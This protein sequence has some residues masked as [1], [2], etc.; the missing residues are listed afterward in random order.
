M[1]EDVPPILWLW[2]VPT[3]DVT[4]TGTAV[5]TPNNI[6]GNAAVASTTDDNGGVGEFSN[7]ANIA[8]VT[9]NTTAVIP[10]NMHI[11]VA[12]TGP[13]IGVDFGSSWSVFVFNQTLG[14]AN[15]MQEGG[16]AGALGNMNAEYDVPFNLPNTGGVNQV[17][18]WD[19]NNLC[20]DGVGTP[21][22][23]L[24]ELT[25]TVV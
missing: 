3:Q 9:I 14:G 5:F 19:A 15:F 17:M 21:T 8:T 6:T 23:I 2:G 24:L 13:G 7:A 25:F 4:G 20:G 16:N 12:Y 22:S 18:E 1:V 11:K 10:C